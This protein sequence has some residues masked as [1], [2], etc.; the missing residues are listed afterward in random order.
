MSQWVQLRIQAKAAQ[1]EACENALLALGALSVTLQD[2]ADQPILEPELG[3]TPI[4]DDTQIIG[5]FDAETHTDAVVEQFPLMFAA[6]GGSGPVDLLWEQV[7]DKDWVR[8]WMDTYKPMQFGPRLW[9]CPSWCKP[10]QPDAVNLMLDPGLAFGTGTHPTTALCL[11]YLDEQIQGNELVVDFG[12]GSGI[13]GMAALL[14]GASSMVGIDIDPQAL[15]ATRD[16]AQRNDIAPERF[17]VY[18]P[19]QAPAIQADVTVAN[20]LAGPLNELA[21]VLAQLTRAGGKLALSGLLSQQADEVIQRYNEWFVMDT[22]K[23]QEDWV[24]ISGTRRQG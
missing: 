24:I 20:I 15:T 16:N 1:V 9:V 3:T 4:W 2:N 11:R 13:L 6:E 14:L 8:A 12:C 22:P 10:P 19:P 5:L 21:P 17:E 7:E 18:L 23:Q